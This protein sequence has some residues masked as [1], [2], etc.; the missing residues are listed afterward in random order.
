LNYLPPEIFKGKN[1]GA[2]PALDIW[3]IGCMLYA[4]V[5]GG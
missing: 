1:V 3:A 2:S 5:I 4:M